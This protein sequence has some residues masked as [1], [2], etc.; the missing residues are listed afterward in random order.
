M[1]TQLYY[2][3][4]TGLLKAWRPT[5][6]TPQQ[7]ANWALIQSVLDQEYVRGFKRGLEVGRAEN[8]N[9]LDPQTE[10]VLFM[11]TRPAEE[12]PQKT[13]DIPRPVL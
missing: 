8:E 9:R 3:K 7:R 12:D 6:M 13:I 5:D 1:S 11:F 10:S 4:E 2:D